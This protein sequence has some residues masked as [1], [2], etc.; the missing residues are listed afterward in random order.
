MSTRIRRGW[1]RNGMAAALFA[2]LFAAPLLMHA[3]AR[4][5]AGV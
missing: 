2:G 1:E 4:Q 5:L 3:L